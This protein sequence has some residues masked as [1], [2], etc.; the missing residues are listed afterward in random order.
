MAQA[1]ALE[2]IAEGVETAAQLRAL[3]DL[4]CELAQGFLF[5]RPLEAGAISEL[6]REEGALREAP[7]G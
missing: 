2:V 5:H 1:L 3:R 4:R 7:C 6:L